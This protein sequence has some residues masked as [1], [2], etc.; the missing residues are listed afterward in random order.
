MTA[1]VLPQ[2]ETREEL[3]DELQKESFD[4]NVETQPAALEEIEIE[5]RFRETAV[6]IVVQRNDFLL[7]NLIDM[8]TVH[9]TVNV[10]P[11]YQRR[12][13][14]D[15]KK[16]S[17]LIE[18]FLVNIP[19]PPVFLYETEFAQYEVM[20]GQ[21]RLS[22]IRQFFANEFDLQGLEL[23]QEL[24]GRRYHELPGVVRAGLDRRSLAAIVL[25]KESSDTEDQS[26]RLR[27]KV[28]ERL[29]TGGVRLNAQEVRNSLQAGRF[30][31]LLHQLARSELFTKI[32]GIPPRE[33]DEDTPGPRLARN[34]Y[35]MRMA[36]NELVLR[37]FALLYPQYIAGGMKKTLDECMGRYTEASSIELSRLESSFHRSLRLAYEIFGPNTFRLPPQNPGR[38]GR[39]SPTL[40]DAVMVAIFRNLELEDELRNKAKQIAAATKERLDKDEFYALVVGRANTRQATIDRST[41]MEGILRAAL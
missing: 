40:Y 31:E 29:N 17:L 35:Y 11:F 21:Q 14:W 23:L 5:S 36:D 22:S 20:D 25:L 3:Q 26:L 33:N 10:S 41:Y 7:P 9:K 8:M 34:S 2:G 15:I 27:Q 39:L 12:L 6:R 1:Q 28:F 38:K 4:D 24:E 18:S 30:N 16:K 13:R 32:W 19:V 37:F